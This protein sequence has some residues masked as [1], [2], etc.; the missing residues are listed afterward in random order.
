MTVNEMRTVV[1]E[2]I[3]VLTAADLSSLPLEP[4]GVASAPQQKRVMI[5]GVPDITTGCCG[6][7]SG[8]LFGCDLAE[9][10]AK[11]SERVAI[12][13]GLTEDDMQRCLRYTSPSAD[14]YGY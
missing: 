7:L 4:F 5:P 11:R 6:P 2:A 3:D 12:L 13:R 8:Y 1:A 14:W 10:E 9:I